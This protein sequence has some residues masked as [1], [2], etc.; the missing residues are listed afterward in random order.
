MHR[1]LSYI[2]VPIAWLKG[3]DICPQVVIKY[4]RDFWRARLSYKYVYY[5]PDDCPVEE[6]AAKYA[7]VFGDVVTR[8][9]KEQANAD[10]RAKRTEA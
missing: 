9:R 5:I 3:R 6:K 8:T 1:I 10:S 2:V 4:R 7:A